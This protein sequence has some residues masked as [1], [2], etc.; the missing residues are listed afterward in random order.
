[1]IS[2]DILNKET[3]NELNKIKE[4]EKTV[5]REN[6]IHR[7]SE[8]TYIFKT[9][10]K[11]KAFGRDIRNG[12]TNLKEAVEDQSRLLFEIINFK[13]K[14]RQQNSEKKKRRMIFLKTCMR[15][16]LVEKEFLMF[17]KVKYY[18]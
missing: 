5:D 10:K 18:Q 8:Y 7:A 13:N 17:L 12:E 2:E 11:I 14:T 4:I 15:I 3:K 1:M 6:L 16:A 9:F